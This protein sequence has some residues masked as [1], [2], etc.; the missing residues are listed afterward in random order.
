MA[1]KGLVKVAVSVTSL[2]PKLSRHG[3]ARRNAGE[4]ARRH[5]RL[6]RPAFPAR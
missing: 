4:V 1:K 5:R 6:L 2:D 3:A